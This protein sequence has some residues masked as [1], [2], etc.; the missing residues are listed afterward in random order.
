MQ[1]RFRLEE[2]VGDA[3]EDG[4]GG[5]ALVWEAKTARAMSRLA[6]G[7]MSPQTL[8]RTAG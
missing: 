2:A 3:A 1:P 6:M 4:P 8:T 5:G 7:A